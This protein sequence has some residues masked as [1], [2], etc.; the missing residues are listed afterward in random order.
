MKRVLLLLIVVWF[1]I[2]GLVPAVNGWGRYN[3]KLRM[4][5]F[6]GGFFSIIFNHEWTRINT[7]KNP[8]PIG[9]R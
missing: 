4:E 7:D 3:L 6:D 5:K 8:S 9:V 2:A 1:F